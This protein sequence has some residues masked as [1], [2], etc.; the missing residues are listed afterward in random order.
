MFCVL[1]VWFC[2]LGKLAG[3]YLVVRHDGYLKKVQRIRLKKHTF[4]CWHM[5]SLSPFYSFVSQIYLMHLLISLTSW[6]FYQM[7]IHNLRL[8]V[9]LMF[10]SEW[11]SL[12]H[13]LDYGQPAGFI[14]SSPCFEILVVFYVCCW[15]IIPLSFFLSF[16]FSQSVDF[17]LSCFN[18]YGQISFYT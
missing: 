17:S 18:K 1:Y 2:L 14:F 11:W 15:L 10:N 16:W 12:I 5:W 3:L 6:N 4:L 7:L 9:V 13:N 8:V